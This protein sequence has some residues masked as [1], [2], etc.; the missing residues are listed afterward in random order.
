MRNDNEIIIND[1]MKVMILINDNG[2][3]NDNDEWY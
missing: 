1:V 3:E 2:N